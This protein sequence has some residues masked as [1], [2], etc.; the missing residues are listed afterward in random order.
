MAGGN[1]GHAFILAGAS[2]AAFF[3]LT[4]R[5]GI[6][7]AS[8]ADALAG[9]Q[10]ALTRERILR[11]LG[12]ALAAAPDRAE[13]YATAVQYARR[14]A[15]EGAEAFLATDAV[16][17]PEDW[18]VVDADLGHGC[19]ALVGPADAATLRARL[20]EVMA[21]RPLVI[22]PLR[23]DHRLTAAVV[24]A[25]GGV[26]N[27]PERLLAAGEAL[28]ST[29]SL[30]LETADLADRLVEERSEQRFGTMIR[31][32][33]D[34]VVVVQQGGTVRYLSPSVTRMLGWEPCEVLDRSIAEI[35]HPADAGRI[36]VA[37]RLA[38]TSPGTYGPIECRVRHKDGS[39]RH[40]EAVGSSLLDDPALAGVVLNVR[41]V[42][43][44]VRLEQQLTHQAL[45]DPL[46][47]LANRTLFLDRV[48]HA[49]E[50]A[51][52]TAS[53]VEILFL[54]LDD[55]KTVND[56]LGHPAGDAV[57]LAVTERLRQCLRSGDTAARLGGDEF[58]VLLDPGVEW[59]GVADRIIA[60]LRSPVVVDGHEVAVRASIG[61]AV[62]GSEVDASDLLRRADLAMY[63]AK[64]EGRTAGSPSSTPCSSSASTRSTSNGPS[65]RPWTR[66][67]WTCGTSRSS[68]S[69]PARPPALRPCSAGSTR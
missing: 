46:T 45:H 63:V 30:A 1:V 42:T 11:S 5:T 29:V 6:L 37:L 25:P 28:G 24:I 27:A 18:A 49:L 50:G 13:I 51:A 48:T 17:A 19:P 33:S 16:L 67:N 31:N 39:W 56:S 23:I 22:V 3:L 53:S 26:E 64:S 60:A 62:G 21:A 61:V 40:L 32:S 14:L 2:A 15:G 8:L 66:V 4:F 44:R 68:T 57:L 38:L 58:G 65:G 43:D 52:R 34:L 35:V 12:T 47:G 41:D 7:N 59:S 55:F 54:D 9:E 69:P 36:M 20:P 10:D